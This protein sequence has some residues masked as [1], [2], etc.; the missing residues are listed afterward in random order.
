M[1]IGHSALARYLLP[2]ALVLAAAC[3]DAPTAVDPT[4]LS[5]AVSSRTPAAL[6]APAPTTAGARYEVKFMSDMIDHHEMAI[7]MAELCVSKAVHAELR[8]LCADII[9]TQRAEMMQMQTWLR[10]WYGISYQ[11][12]MKPGDMR[13]IE[14]MAALPAAEF[15]VEFMQMMIKHH[16]KAVK[17]GED[18][19][20]R[21]YHAELIALCEN[22]IATQSRERA[23]MQQ[24]LCAWYGICK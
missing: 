24:W 13:M 3:G 10:T 2:A 21:A 12:E 4:T 23:Q 22:I 20:D 7:K 18:C 5:D 15:E 8:T 16:S 14:K 17:E 19:L 9:A 6:S 1:L 11:P